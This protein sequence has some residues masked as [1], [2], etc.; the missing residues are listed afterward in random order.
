MN[1]EEFRVPKTEIKMPK[2]ENVVAKEDAAIKTEEPDA[3]DALDA[4]LFDEADKEFEAEQRQREIDEFE[5]IG[6]SEKIGRL[7][8]ALEFLERAKA[9]NGLGYKQG[10]A[11]HFDELDK[12]EE[13][14]FSYPIFCCKEAPGVYTFVFPE[15]L[16]SKKK[17]FMGHVPDMKLEFSYIPNQDD[18]DV[19]ININQVSTRNPIVS[20]VWA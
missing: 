9:N 4:L 17:T 14:L 13:G 8:L 3:F 15:Q 10:S 19:R 5:P 18:V 7:T 11:A 2:E 16:L 12:E 6:F 20:I 1:S